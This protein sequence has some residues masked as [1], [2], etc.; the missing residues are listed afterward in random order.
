MCSNSYYVMNAEQIVVFAILSLPC[1]YIGLCEC[2]VPRAI[3]IPQGTRATYVRRQTYVNFSNAENRYLYYAPAYA[4]ETLV[5]CPY[6]FYGQRIYRRRTYTSRTRISGGCFWF[7]DR[8][9]HHGIH[10]DSITV[11]VIVIVGDI[12]AMTHLKFRVSVF[13]DVSIS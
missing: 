2:T 13:S 3:H 10:V 8:P 6:L 4:C 12:V 11:V 5:T 7:Y 9:F 1:S